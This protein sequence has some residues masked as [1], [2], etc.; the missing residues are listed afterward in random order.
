MVN[1][2]RHEEC[3]RVMAF[4]QPGN[5]HKNEIVVHYDTSLPSPEY[6][7]VHELGRL[8][9]IA[10]APR[11]YQLKP[12]TTARTMNRAI[13]RMKKEFKQAGVNPPFKEIELKSFYL[14]LSGQ[15]VHTPGN[16]FIGK[17]LLAFYPE[18]SRLL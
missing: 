6:N 11:K 2:G 18:G 13:R 8:I 3:D 14:S 16:C 15:L 9:R 17:C 4:R 10:Q 5:Q 1:L 12:V 7:L